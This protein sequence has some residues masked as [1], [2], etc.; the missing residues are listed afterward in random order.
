MNKEIIYRN[1]ANIKAKETSHN[2]G[3]KQVL[4][5]N[6]ET[7]TKLTQVAF[8]ILQ[9]SEIVEEHSHTD[10]EECFCF[11]EGRGIYLLDQ[12]P[13]EVSEGIF[14]KIPINVRHELKVV[15]KMPLKFIYWGIEI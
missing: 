15:G 6:N 7:Q 3:K 1:L 13:F 14:I 8:G 5:A 4:L 9:P 10:M 2:A 11:T 12:E